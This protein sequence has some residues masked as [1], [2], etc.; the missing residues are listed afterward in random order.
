M[1]T[2][3]SERKRWVDTILSLTLESFHNYTQCVKLHTECKI[4]LGVCKKLSVINHWMGVKT[5]HSV[6]ILSVKAQSVCVNCD[7]FTLCI[8]T[9]TQ[10]T[11][12]LSVCIQNVLF[13][14]PSHDFISLCIFTHTECTQCV[15]LHTVCN[16]EMY[17]HTLY[18]I[19][20]TPLCKITVCIITHVV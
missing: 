19:T 12:T 15:V 13:L 5:T 9:H 3:Y 2:R 7:F 1:K 17:I 14:Y 8:F 18:K 16:Y 4:T 10:C 20:K 11:F 6:Y